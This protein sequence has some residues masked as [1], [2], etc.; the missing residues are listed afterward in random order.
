MAPRQRFARERSRKT[1]HHTDNAAAVAIAAVGGHRLN[2]PHL[3]AGAAGAHALE[4]FR[5]Q[6]IAWATVSACTVQAGALA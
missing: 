5:T 1:I 3:V 4:E 2:L 6:T